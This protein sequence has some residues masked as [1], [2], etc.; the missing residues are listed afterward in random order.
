MKPY[1]QDAYVT[2]WHGDCR[3]LL[4]SVGCCDLLLTDPPYGIGADTR[5]A[6]RAGKR[7][8][9]AAT[10]SRD[11][12]ISTWDDAVPDQWVI[13]MVRWRARWSIIWGGNYFDLPPAAGWLVWDKENGDNGYADCELAWTNLPQAIRMKRYRWMG[14]LQGNMK[15]KEY[16]SHPTQKPLPL[17]LWCLTLVPD[18]ATVLDPFAGSG[19]TLVAAKQ[20]GRKAF[21]IEA[22]EAYCEDIAQRC[23]QESLELGA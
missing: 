5:Q 2:L 18:A 11:Y 20:L 16:R 14:M 12:G 1:Y 15:E 4:P 3:E 17:M 13:D 9:A 23:S 8:G 6:A 19:T 10:I 7:H 22:N 21:G